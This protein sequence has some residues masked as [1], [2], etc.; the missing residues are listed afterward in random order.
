MRR[1]LHTRS[2][3][4]RTRPRK[5]AVAL[6]GVAWTPSQLR[7]SDDGRGRI[8]RQGARPEAIRGGGRAP[9]GRG[10]A[11]GHAPLGSPSQEKGGTVLTDFKK[12]ILRGN[13]VDLAVGVVMGVAFGAVITAI[14]SGLLTP[15]IAA[16]VGKPQFSKL[17][18]TIH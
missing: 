15:I 17:H 7:P 8:S 18:F 9:G 14:V 2:R 4:P 16:V 11:D 6:G 13:V 12:F 1:P 10:G 3:R 5:A